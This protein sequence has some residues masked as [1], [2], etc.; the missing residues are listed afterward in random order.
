[1]W[2]FLILI[3]YAINHIFDGL[4]LYLVKSI[5]PTDYFSTDI[6]YYENVSQVF[7]DKM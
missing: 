4:V 2:N 7:H 5:G 3:Q 6:I 1:M